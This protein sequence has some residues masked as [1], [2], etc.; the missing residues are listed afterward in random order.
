MTLNATDEKATCQHC[1]QPIYRS[2]RRWTP[3]RDA[4]GMCWCEPVEGQPD[5]MHQ[6]VERIR[7]GKAGEEATR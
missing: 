7:A 1:R 4:D 3:W 5:T 6:P 2:N